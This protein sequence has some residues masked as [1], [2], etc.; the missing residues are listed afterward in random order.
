MIITKVLSV[1]TT[2]TPKNAGRLRKDRPQWAVSFKFEGET[3]YTTG[4]KRF[5]SDASHIAILPKGCS[6]YW[7]CTKAGHVSMI[8]FESAE[9]YSEP[10]I[11]PVKNSEKIAKIFNGLEYQRN[12]KRP[13]SELESIRDTYSIILSL[14]LSQNDPEKY[15]SGDKLQ[16]ILPAVKYLSQ[17]YNKSITNDRL[18][19]LTGVST[20]YFR[21]LFSEAMHTSPIA[22]AHKLRIEKAKELLKSDYGTLSDLARSLG[23][24]NLYDFSRDF[25]NHTGVAPSKYEKQK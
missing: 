22:Y 24:A 6:Y 4:E 12:L 9:V 18:A 21:R 10:L 23:Y 5:L 7:Q 14:C 19:A 3:V 11:F 2:Y 25:K 20:A 16:K 15:V 13:F 1:S 8:E 17:N